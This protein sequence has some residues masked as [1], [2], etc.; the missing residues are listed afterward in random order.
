MINYLDYIVELVKKLRATNSRTEKE[1]ILKEEWEFYKAKGGCFEKLLHAV[2]DYDKQYYVTSAN[3]LKF[4]DTNK[5]YQLVV[6]EHSINFGYEYLLWD[7]L[8]DLSNRVIT[9]YAALTSVNEF[10]RQKCD[11]DEQR[12]IVL[13][14]IDKDLKCGL[15]VATIN[16]V[17]PNL[18]PQFKVA[19]AQKLDKEVLDETY[20]VSRKLDGCFSYSAPVLLADGTVKPIGEIVENKLPVEVLSYNIKTNTVEPKKVINWFNNGI[21]NNWLKIEN[22]GINLRSRLVR[23]NSVIVTSNHRFFNGKDYTEIKDADKVYSPV[24]SVNPTQAQV[25]YGSLLGDGS[26]KIEKR[27]KSRVQARISFGNSVKQKDYFDK[28]YECLLPIMGKARSQISGF[29]SKIFYASTKTIPF[30]NE[31]YKNNSVDY[32]LSKLG[33][34]GMTIWYLDDGSRA[35]EKTELNT[36]NK[37]SRVKL[38]TYAFTLE[39]NNKIC[40]WLNSKG[41]DAKI[42]ED[43]RGKGYWIDLRSAGS[44]KFFKDIASYVPVSMEYKLPAYLRGGKKVEWWKDNKR[45]LGLIEDKIVKKPSSKHM[46][47]YDIEVEDNHNYFVNGMLVHNCRLITVAKNKNDITFYSRQ[48]KEFTTLGVLRE[49]IRKLFTLGL[50]HDNTVLDGEVCIVDENGKEDFQ[51]IMKEIKRKDHT[52]QNPMYILFDYLTL[53]EFNKG[54]SKFG[55]RDRM[56][57]LQALDDC[58]ALVNPEFRPK[59]IR[60]VEHFDYTPE[61]FKQWQQKVIDNGW[62]GLIARKDVPYENKRS[63]NMLKIKSFTDEEFKVIGVEEGDAQELINGVMVKIKCVGALTIEYK[64]NKVGVGTGLSLEQRKRWYEHPEE[65]IGKVITVKY[66]ESTID[67]NG[68]PSLRFPVLKAIY[69]GERDL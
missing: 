36:T 60:V 22:K 54:T 39:E 45:C 1:R 16:K 19:L 62:E 47:A 32:L 25:L 20:V 64:G 23:R 27:C 48:G 6:K 42:F 3:V 5:D 52:I 38:S 57:S 51:S 43:K 65:I 15:S 58:I 49:N 50:L 44:Q 61:E 56:K 8:R 63:A 29:G 24:L 17:I 10:L 2:Y 46:V 13:D 35:K 67:Q 55:Y 41:Y 18:I 14:I 69:E 68:K 26:I 40:D 33:P 11:N 66:F 34:L 37:F 28:K 12:Q 4:R 31:L 53:D 9:G 30:I 59:G 7:L 21:K